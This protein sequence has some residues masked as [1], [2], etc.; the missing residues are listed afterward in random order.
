MNLKFLILW[1][2]Y[3]CSKF[4]FFTFLELNFWILFFKS[5]IIAV[6]MRLSVVA[7]KKWPTNG[8]VTRRN[9][10]LRC[11]WVQWEIM[12]TPTATA[13]TTITSMTAWT[14]SSSLLSV[15]QVALWFTYFCLSNTKNATCIHGKVSMLKLKDASFIIFFCWFA[16]IKNPDLSHF[17][18]INLYSKKIQLEKKQS[19][20]F[21]CNLLWAKPNL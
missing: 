16:Q 3:F 4:V 20:L 15:S 19:N 18:W 9:R 12:S 5:R 8:A 21:T 2:S 13:P 11:T 10:R 14:R 1:I 6:P 7:S 17:T